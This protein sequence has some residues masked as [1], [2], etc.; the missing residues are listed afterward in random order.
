[1]VDGECGG[2]L[3]HARLVRVGGPGVGGEAENG[4]GRGCGAAVRYELRKR[5]G[6]G[7][8]AVGGCGGRAE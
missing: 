2:G 5:V 3:M 6:A 8:R 4:V 1:M 7:R